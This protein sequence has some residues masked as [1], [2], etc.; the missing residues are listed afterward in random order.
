MDQSPKKEARTTVKTRSTNALRT[1]LKYGLKAFIHDSRS[2]GILLLLCTAISLILCNWPGGSDL[3][4]AYS[5]FWHQEITVLSNLGHLHG[6]HLPHS[7]IELINDLLM[8]VFF[9][10]AGME[11]KRELV[12]GELSTPKKAGLPMIAAISGVAFP[13]IIFLL[14]NRGTGFEHGWGI[15]TATDIAF[16]LGVAALLGSRV[17]Y[18]LKIFLTALAIIDDLCAILIIALFYGGEIA[19]GWLLT[20][21]GCLVLLWGINKIK[22]QPG[23]FKPIQHILRVL[24]ALLLWYSVLQSGIHPTIAGILFAFM[25]PV[26]QLTVYEKKVHIPVNFIIIPLFALA[27]TCIFLPATLG[28]VIHSSVS[29]GILLGLFIGK[30]LGIGLVC[31]MVVRAGWF[32]LP[33][34]AS[35]S[36]FIGI[37]ILAGIG[38]TMSIF[39]TALAYKEVALQ[40]DAKL[41]IL[42]AS[43]L[44]MVTGYIWL[45]RS[46]KQNT[47][48]LSID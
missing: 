1:K 30:P 20:A 22:N 21:A 17:P 43:V 41:A 45:Y 26:D 10:L 23:Y 2:V 28:S 37:G 32:K 48:G 15:P 34:G 6:M 18:S 8:A 5:G 29:W 24:V 42:L 40:T 36:Q 35:W 9:F 27:N 25:I 38:F 39:V 31:F 14:L 16:S 19:G 44:A 13:A 46:G 12:K 47:H 4:T 11:I 7:P 33:K 3:G